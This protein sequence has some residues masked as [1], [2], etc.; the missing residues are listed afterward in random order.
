MNVCALAIYVFSPLDMCL[1]NLY[2]NYLTDCLNA[3][4]LLNRR[5]I[6]GKGKRSSNPTFDA[7][8]KYLF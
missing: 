8:F 5:H 3:L 2:I 7:Y 4:Y 6:V 1:C